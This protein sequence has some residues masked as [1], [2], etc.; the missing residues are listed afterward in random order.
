MTKR[1]FVITITVS[2]R[3]ALFALGLQK[4]DRSLSPLTNE[5]VGR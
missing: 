2:V 4:D 5:V 1:H 3:S